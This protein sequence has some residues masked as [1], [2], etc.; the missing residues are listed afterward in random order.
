[1]LKNYLFF[2]IFLTLLLSCEKQKTETTKTDT[3]AQDFDTALQDSN[4]GDTTQEV[5]YAIAVLNP[6][7]NNK[8]SGSVTFTKV[9]DGIK[10]VADVQGLTP[11]KHGFHIHEKGDCSAPDASSAGDHFNPTGHQHGDAG[12]NSHAGDFG[13]LT[14]DKNGKAHLEITS[15]QLSFSGKNS[16]LNR[17]VVVHQD[18]DDL[19][20]QPAGKSGPRIA[21]GVIT[22]NNMGNRTGK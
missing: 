21:C 9:G 17:A 22:Q 16:I 11:G 4:L 13:N 7:Q 20:S 19:K 5:S 8:A 12:E 6:T 2:F 10:I 14:A 18:P 3:T 1:M 15:K